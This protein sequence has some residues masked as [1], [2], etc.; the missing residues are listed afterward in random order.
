MQKTN[1]LILR[2]IIHLRSLS[3]RKEHEHCFHSNIL[4]LDMGC[5]QPHVLTTP[6][7]FRSCFWNA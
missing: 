7:I 6:T 2:Y 4:V 3:G 5:G 1:I